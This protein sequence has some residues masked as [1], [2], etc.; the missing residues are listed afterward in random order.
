MNKA[1]IKSKIDT[2]NV[3]YT[4]KESNVKVLC[5]HYFNYC[6]NCKICIQIFDEPIKIETVAK[7][8]T[9]NHEYKKTESNIKVSYTFLTF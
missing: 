8:D 9:K 1:E 3:N 5:F 2:R 7:I 6:N 4:K